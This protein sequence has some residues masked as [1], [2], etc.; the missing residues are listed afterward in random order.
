MFRGMHPTRQFLRH[1][2]VT[3]GVLIGISL[4]RDA[5]AQQATTF[6]RPFIHESV[7]A[8]A[9]VVDRE[10]FDAGIAARAAASLREQGSRVRRCADAGD[11]GGE[12]RRV[13]WDGFATGESPVRHTGA[14]VIRYRRSEREARDVYDRV[15]S[16]A[17]A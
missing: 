11:V 8:L 10:Y 1:T 5:T 3:C 12:T 15:H 6:D 7:E 9:T 2:L 14:A 13:T 4:G 16:A 17:R